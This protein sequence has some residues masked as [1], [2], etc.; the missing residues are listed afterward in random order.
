[1]NRFLCAGYLT[2]HLRGWRYRII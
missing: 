1:M 2:H